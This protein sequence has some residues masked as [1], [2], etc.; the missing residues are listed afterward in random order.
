MRV[1][2]PSG[3]SLAISE[4]FTTEDTGG[5]KGRLGIANTAHDVSDVVFLEETDGGDPG[6]SGFEAEASVL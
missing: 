2:S 5:H 4:R 3:F 6:G 1:P